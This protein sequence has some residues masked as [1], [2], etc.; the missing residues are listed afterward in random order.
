ME[1]WSAATLLAAYGDCGCNKFCSD[2]GTFD[3]VPYTSLVEVWITCATLFLILPSRTLY[4]PNIFECIYD[5]TALYEYGIPI[6]APKC[7]TIS[8]F[9]YCI[10]YEIFIP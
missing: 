3:G 6:K 10:K 9:F 1:S 4:V 7:K 8:F 5:A 2:I